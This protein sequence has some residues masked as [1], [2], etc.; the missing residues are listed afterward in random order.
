MVSKAG[1]ENVWSRGKQL[2]SFTTTTNGLIWRD[3]KD[4][5][6]VKVLEETDGSLKLFE[7]VLIKRLF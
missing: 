3:K 1:A 5:A 2:W 6:P 7:D 4:G